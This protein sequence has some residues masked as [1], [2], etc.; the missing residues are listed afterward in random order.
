M[1]HRSP[2]LE[3]SATYVTLMTRTKLWFCITLIAFTCDTLLPNKEA[4][5][6]IAIRRRPEFQHSLPV[7]SGGCPRLRIS[8]FRVYDLVLAVFFSTSRNICISPCYSYVYLLAL[9]TG[10][11][12]LSLLIV[13]SCLHRNGCRM[14]KC[15]STHMT[16]RMRMDAV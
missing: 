8:D 2:S 14:A 9:F 15:L 12:T 3:E 11:L 5:Y 4:S 16:T 7:V 10:K 1:E 6:I 13:S